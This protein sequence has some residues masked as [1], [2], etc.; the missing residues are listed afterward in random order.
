MKKF[1]SLFCIMMLLCSVFTIRYSAEPSDSAPSLKKYLSLDSITGTGGAT[2]SANNTSMIY[3]NRWYTATD[4]FYRLP[5]QCWGADPLWGHISSSKDAST[6]SVTLTNNG[7]GINPP[8]LAYIFGST[9]RSD[10][11]TLKIPVYSD[12]T[13]SASATEHCNY[14]FVIMYGAVNPVDSS[15]SLGFLEIGQ[16]ADGDYAT[17]NTTAINNDSTTNI[18]PFDNTQN[19]MNGEN[20]F[21]ISLN[22]MVNGI[23]N[24]VEAYIYSFN[25]VVDAQNAYSLTLNDISI[26][27]TVF[28][29][30]A[31][32]GSHEGTVDGNSVT[33][34][35]PHSSNVAALTPE[36]DNAENV[37]VSP[38]G[39]QDFS[40]GFVTYTFTSANAT[41][42]Y[43]IFVKTEKLKY[44]DLSTMTGNRGWIDGGNLVT[45]TWYSANADAINFPY[46]SWGLSDLWGHNYAVKE[47]NVITIY[48]KGEGPNPSSY[49][50]L[51]GANNRCSP[52][53]EA[54][55]LD[56]YL[57][58]DIKSN[59]DY[60]FIIV[61]AAVNPDDG[62]NNYGLMEIFK[63]KNGKTC[64]NITNA[65]SGGPNAAFSTTANLNPAGNEIGIIPLAPMSMGIKN[66]TEAY[67]Y[68]FDFVVTAENSFYLSMNF[69]PP[70]DFDDTA[71]ELTSFSLGGYTAEIADKNVSIELPLGLDYSNISPIYT[72]SDGAWGCFNDDYTEF[73]V[74]SAYGSTKTAYT[75]DIK[76]F[77]LI[78][79]ANVDGFLN[80]ADLTLVRKLLLSNDPFDFDAVNCN[81][82]DK[83]D[84]RD[85][86]F[87]KKELA[88]FI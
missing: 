11:P 17:Y 49:R 31:T 27:S 59:C 14:K 55:S 3:T 4:E 37:T 23:D 50:Y 60:K 82:D 76:T 34:T 42:K 69:T 48:N 86:I 61:F 79:D 39:P 87:I 28:F 6:G 16:D 44:L 32:I 62:S 36:F 63:D 24:C 71:C 46:E 25:V 52:P 77:R 5:G 83:F 85:L 29:G 2:Y 57:Y 38:S 66:C 73:T 80:A 33:F 67:I 56:S 20:T 26:Q 75:V 58:F 74:T 64:Y 30:K 51:F 15:H 12:I 43:N 65:L 88:K 10:M 35:L 13:I 18:A 19:M 47:D 40:N 1:I 8:S 70:D 72:A 41:N 53:S 7:E 78:G 81:G 84:I 45:D 22:E 54:I 21:T 68:S 9:V